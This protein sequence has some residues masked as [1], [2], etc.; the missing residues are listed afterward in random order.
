[1]RKILSG[2]VQ[3]TVLILGL[4]VAGLGL[5]VQLDAMTYVGLSVFAVGVVLLAIDLFRREGD[6]SRG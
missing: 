6:N 1:M 3:A 5:T 4:G 2:E